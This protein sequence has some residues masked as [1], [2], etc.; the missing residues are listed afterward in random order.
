[1]TLYL[2]I[3]NKENPVNESRLLNVRQIWS[4]IHTLTSPNDSFP[5]YAP[6]K[7]VKYILATFVQATRTGVGISPADFSDGYTKPQNGAAIESINTGGQFQL[8]IMLDLTINQKTIQKM[9]II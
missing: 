5:L 3:T 8:L 1:M 2:C 4:Q 9:I 6:T 7:N